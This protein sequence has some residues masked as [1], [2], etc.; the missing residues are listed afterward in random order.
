MQPEKLGPF[1]IGRVLG[2]G[3]MG[4][5]YEGFHEETGEIA[6]VKVLLDTFEEENDTRLRF[7][8]EI[9]TLKR[10]RHPNIVRLFGFGKDQGLLYYVMELVDG[11]SLYN[12]LKQKRFFHWYEVAKIGMEI[13]QALRHAHDRGVIHRDVKPANILLEKNGTIKLSDFGIAS[14]FGSQ[15]LTDNNAVVG[16]LEYMSPEQA[17]AYPVGP[18]S[19]MYSLGTVLYSLILNKPPFIAKNLAEIIKKHQENII[20]PIRVTR[21]D[22]PEEME[23]IVLNLLQVQSEVRPQSPFAVARRFQTLLQMQFG[24]IEKIIIRPTNTTDNSAQ[25]INQSQDAIID[26]S[27]IP[28][29]NDSRNNNNFLLPDSSNKNIN[30]DADITKSITNIEQLNLN[31]NS[32]L[33]TTQFDFDRQNNNNPP[34]NTSL[35]NNNISSSQPEINNNNNV[36][37]NPVS[38][39]KDDLAVV[40]KP[41]V[42]DKSKTDTTRQ[43][44]HL[45]FTRVSEHELDGL[46]NLRTPPSSPISLQTIFASV[47]LLLIGGIIY[48]LLQP[49]SPDILY[50]RIQSKLHSKGEENNFSV[51]S[52]RRAE[53]E[54]RFFLDHYADHQRIGQVRIYADQLDIA[55][56]ERRL[57]RR[58]QFSDPASISQV[59]RAYLEATSWITSDPM[60][61]I[62][63][64]K[65]VI[66]L[67]GNDTV[68]L[69]IETNDNN[70]NENNT[71]NKI[72]PEF[73]N[74]EIKKNYNRRLQSP[75]EMC[76]ELARRRLHEIEKTI[77]TI[78]SD[79]EAFL[80]KR[81][82]DAKILIESEEPEQAQK[83]LSGI[84]ELYGSQNWAAKYINESNKLLD[85]IKIKIKQKNK[86][87][88]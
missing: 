4:V 7:E 20:E 22:V 61:A 73:S 59:E 78:T 53:S 40:K 75:T 83:I 50:D 11:A 68:P 16:T 54:I 36:L 19:D 80:N 35:K 84:I 60:K 51:E 67:F 8:A 29:D 76:V 39:P 58:R 27:V 34:V 72:N 52:L 87:S 62:S 3:G 41:V 42:A 71:D 65:A 30:D 64:L 82:Q 24:Q 13:C 28:L 25:P 10:L 12:E 32:N 17:L 1:Q 43:T 15:H 77:E 79:Q 56:L 33:N 46:S 31:N 2:R 18:R 37:P 66:D 21:I 86:N 63:K 5:V 26:L 49:V 81:I 9:D 74:G 57:E 88:N 45:I 23:N 55:N 44:Q 14:L 69:K 85:K 47:C 70:S 38:Q 48:Y 6:A